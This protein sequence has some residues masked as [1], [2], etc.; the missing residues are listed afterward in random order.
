MIDRGLRAQLRSADLLTGQLYIAFDFFPGVVTKKGDVS[1]RKADV[2]ASQALLA[3]PTIPNTAEETQTQISEIARKLNK[4]PFDQI[5]SELQ[6]S[7]KT[8]QRTLN[9]A[10]QLTETLN[11]D[12][13]PEI[14]VAMKDVHETLN[15]AGRTLSEEAPLQQDLR[16]TLQELSRAAISLRVVTDYLERHPESIIRGKR[17]DKR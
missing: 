4:V 3:I 2:A 5:G 17:E 14:A 1:K 13:A 16:Q 11:N 9:S 8:L 7:L 15:A 10:G 12:V 6:E